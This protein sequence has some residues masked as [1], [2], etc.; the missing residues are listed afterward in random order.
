MPKKLDFNTINPPVLE[1][2]MPDA[3]KTQIDVTTPSEKLVEELQTIAPHMS[4]ALAADD[5]ETIP[6]I[7][8]LAA[9][10]ISCNRQKLQVT[11]DDLRNK[12]K[13]NLEALLVFYNTYLDFLNEI[14][15]AKN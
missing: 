1:L 5:N 15:D 4:E 3:D 14:T 11:V 9:R 12:Y 7:Y 8:D 10:L 6:A 13:L 2:V